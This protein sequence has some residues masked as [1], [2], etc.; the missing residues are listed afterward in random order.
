[1]N[2][3]VTGGA[4]YVGAHAAK[5]FARAGHRPVVF[6]SLSTGHACAVRWGALVQGDIRD[7]EALAAAMR[8][9][10]IDLVAHFAAIPDIPTCEAK[11]RLCW[12]VNV[13]GTDAVL[14]AMRL[15]GVARIVASST[16]ATYSP[17]DLPLPETAGRNP[18]SLYGR[19]KLAAEA[20]FLEAVRTDGIGVV[21]LRYF[22]VAGADPDGE[23][24]ERHDPETHLIPIVLQ[25]A[26]GLRPSVTINGADYGTPDG[27]CIRDYVH[28]TDVADAHVRALQAVE[29]PGWKAMNIGTGRGYSIREVIDTARAVTGRP[30]PVTV[31]PRR[32][33][34]PPHLVAD[35]GLAA[36]ELGWRPERS[37]LLCMIED[38]WRWMT[39][40]PAPAAVPMEGT[41]L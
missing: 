38:A 17:D 39:D 19:S 32:G 11:P 25:V 33:A 40:D 12:D 23:V 22:N 4:G 29:A 27:T 24:G 31:G 13:R 7:V 16:C 34:D 14:A 30:I 10:A 9:H 3:L 20:A 28:V 15:A 21:L 5:A 18:I 41:V 35:A 26:A 8:D 36:A 1:M 37:S 2:I 6:D